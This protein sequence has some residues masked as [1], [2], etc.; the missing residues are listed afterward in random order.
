MNNKSAIV[1]V[2]FFGILLFTGLLMLQTC[3]GPPSSDLPGSFRLVLKASC[4]IA[5]DEQQ[6][7]S[8]MTV[9]S[10]TFSAG[11]SPDKFFIPNVSLVRIDKQIPTSS[12]SAS[13]DIPSSL[14][15]YF[16]TSLVEGTQFRD[17][18]QDEEQIYFSNPYRDPEFTDFRSMALRGHAEDGELPT[19]NCADSNEFFMVDVLPE[20]PPCPNKY[21]NDAAALKM[22]L[23]KQFGIKSPTQDVVIYYLCG[24]GQSTPTSSTAVNDT[25]GDSVEDSKDECPT[26]TGKPV[27][28]GCPDRDNDGV[29]DEWDL[30]PNEAGDAG[31]NG[32]PNGVKKAIEVTGP[33]SKP[34][35]NVIISHNNNS[36]QF[37]VSKF[38]VNSMLAEVT[39]KLRSGKEIKVT[40]SSNIFPASK[41]EFNKLSQNITQGAGLEVKY[42][43]LDKETREVLTTFEL[44]DVSLVCIPAS[45][46]KDTE[47][48]FVQM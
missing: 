40:P 26:I 48:G 14:M 10:T 11:N 34:K 30:C 25:D 5:K 24:K 32:C 31:N 8:D 29:K 21:W 22:H 18:R 45:N 9:L 27:H 33:S 1:V 42:V 39:I 2:I 6:F 17:M 16:K 15:H 3:D 38:D 35:A 23:E 37:I 19:I 43:V 20:N 46:G 7:I 12:D 47:C 44:K 41:A 13:F 4:P 28:N 36:G